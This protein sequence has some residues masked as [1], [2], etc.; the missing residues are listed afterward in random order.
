MRARFRERGY[1]SKSITEAEK[2][3]DLRTRSDFLAPRER[4]NDEKIRFITGYSSQSWE[5]RRSLRYEPRYRE[6]ASKIKQEVPDAE[7]CGEKGRR[8]CFEVKINDKLIFSKLESGEFPYHEDIVNA[9]KEVKE[10]QPIS[11]ITKVKKRK[12]I[13]Q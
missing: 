10:G 8:G 5:V 11:K 6:L 2:N 1:S 7:V 9:V 4:Q 13:L 12:C 3:V